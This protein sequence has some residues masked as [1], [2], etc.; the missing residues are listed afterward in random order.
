MAETNVAPSSY[1]DGLFPAVH[2]PK[3]ARQDPELYSAVRPPP[4]SALAAL[5]SRLG[6]IPVGT[7]AETKNRRI[8]LVH[9]AC[10]HSTFQS[11]VDKALAIE[12]SL[13][14]DMSPS[15]LVRHRKDA[16][17]DLD[18][19]QYFPASREVDSQATLSTLGNSLLG[20]V[21]TEYLH[22]RYPNLPTRVLKAAV[23]GYVGT[24]TLSNVA[25]TLGFGAKGIMRWNKNARREVPNPK[26]LEHSPKQ[27]PQQEER[28]SEAALIR[29][30]A[31]DSFRAVV[32]LVFQE[33]G[34][35]AVR[36]FI[37]AHLLNRSLDLAKM[38]KFNDPKRA[39]TS[40]CIKYG[41]ELP[42]SRIVAETGRLSINPIFVV[43]VWSGVTK[44]GEGSGSSIR[45]A[46]FRAA[47]DALRRLYL[48]ETPLGDFDVP[49]ST[50]DPLYPG[51]TPSSTSSD[52]ASYTAQPIGES[53]VLL[54]A[55]KSRH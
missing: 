25:F 6:L 29:D 27:P 49:S 20:M 19:A 26:S 54:A 38:L 30:V 45:M 53:E 46:E 1:R 34:L 21:A 51:T 11:V 44:I 32:A 2:L 33:Q 41:K 4:I 14:T 15:G 52:P 36:R 16:K 40:T 42:Q 5:T 24:L 55:G 43:G 37:T 13:T 3:L 8:K 7:D 9:Q 23:S 22:L 12:S 17:V 48:T 39:L 28:S 50:L 31:A 47:E 18:A 10:T 35:S